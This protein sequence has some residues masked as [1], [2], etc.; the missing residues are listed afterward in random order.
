MTY[1]VEDAGA[2]DDGAS[3]LEVG[4]AALVFESASV[5]P[6]VAGAELSLAV[7]LAATVDDAD[8][9]TADEE[10]CPASLALIDDRTADFISLSESRS[11]S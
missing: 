10:V 7:V 9:D 4:S 8:P 1:S 11:S 6:D 3:A 5:D 2:A